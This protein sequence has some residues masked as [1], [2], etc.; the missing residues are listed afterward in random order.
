MLLGEWSDQELDLARLVE[1]GKSMPC[2]D[3]EVPSPGLRG[4]DNER[5][6]DA[7]DRLDSDLW[8]D[9]RETH[10][11]GAE[12]SVP[13]VART[14][15]SATR[16]ATSGATLVLQ[17]LAC[18]GDGVLLSLTVDGRPA[19]AWVDAHAWCDWI[20]QW[21]ERTDPTTNTE[22]VTGLEEPAA[23]DMARDLRP[24]PFNRTR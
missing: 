10:R 7:M 2:A 9:P 15:G 5:L 20:A 22:R 4:V 16:S 19:T 23:A 18:G 24:S 21:S 1:G 6:L 12:E 11:D 13:R 14:T 8:G 17:Q 3:E